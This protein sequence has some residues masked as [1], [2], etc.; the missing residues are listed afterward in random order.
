[1]VQSGK[2]W[3]DSS[4][5]IGEFSHSIDH[6]GRLAIP[7]KFRE[8][9]SAGGILTR[10]L[11][12]CLFLFGKEAWEVISEKLRNLP[13]TASAARTFTRYILSGASE[14][15]FDNL[16]RVMIPIFLR[17]YA[18]LKESVVV[19]G[20]GSRAEIWNKQAWEKYKTQAEKDSEEKAGELVG[21]GI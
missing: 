17:E 21:S 15:G 20:V 2:K 13:I 1:M 12:G 10:G 7:K 14:V 16:G 18:R 6:K 4:M 9:L 8:R 5:F 19:I 3:V 11:D